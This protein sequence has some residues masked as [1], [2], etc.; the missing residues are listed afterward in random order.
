MAYLRN[1]LTKERHYL[2]DHHTFGRRKETVD[3]AILQPEISKIHAVISWNG[4][5]WEIR[6]LSRN[7]TWLD[8]KKLPPSVNTGLMKGQII[9]FS[10][11][12]KNSW[13]VEDLS[14]PG[15]MLIGLNAD[16]P[17]Q[18]LS[19]Y[20]LLPDSEMPQAALYFCQTRHQWILERRNTESLV[21]ETP[22]EVVIRANQ[23]VVFANYQWS[24]FLINRDA[25]T[26]EISSEKTHVK[27]CL[28]D[29]DVSLNEEHISLRVEHESTAVDL[30]E[31]SHHY[32]LL[33]LARLKARDVMQ[34][35][36]SNNQGWISNE[37]LAKELGLDVSYINI[38]IF[39]ARKQMADAFPTME[40]MAE[41]IERRRG[42]VRF[43]CF[44]A[45]IKKGKS[46]EV[47]E[48]QL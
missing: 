10:G 48:R 6:D 7:G 14:P 31:R 21:S 1:V 32:L 33:H 4:D 20:H 47:L 40:G 9:C 2:Q 36:D 17:T 44:E 46:S 37:L 19:S 24:L 39:R 8:D 13:E 43:N 30:F 16:S 29:F 45:R 23:P 35:I 42:E 25:P 26:Q 12:D 5:G 27:D 22:E 18:T 3:T 38:Q 15:N 11:A 28:F 41:L 34:G